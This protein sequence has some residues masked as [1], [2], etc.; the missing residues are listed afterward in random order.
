MEKE[1]GL[2]D[3]DLIICKPTDRPQLNRV[4][5]NILNMN[6]CHE[7]I[8]LQSGNR[9]IIRLSENGILSMRKVQGLLEAPHAGT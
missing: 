3:D 7:H 8:E 4:P 6:G 9:C 2:V 1:I 5:A